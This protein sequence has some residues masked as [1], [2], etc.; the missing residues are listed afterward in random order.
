MA[1]FQT[2]DPNLGK[3]FEGLVMDNVGIIY[4]AIWST[5]RPFGIFCGDLVHFTV[6]WYIFSRFGMLYKGKSGS[7]AVSSWI[8]T[9]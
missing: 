6:I 2:K 7:P 5:L 1:Y 9:L 3:I 4:R 8:C